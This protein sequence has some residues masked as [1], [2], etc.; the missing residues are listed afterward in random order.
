M[1][2][3]KFVVQKTCRQMFIFL[4]ML[5]KSHD[6]EEDESLQHEKTS[7]NESNIYAQ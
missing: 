2:Y 7:K 4:K 1:T 6:T 3:K 5:K